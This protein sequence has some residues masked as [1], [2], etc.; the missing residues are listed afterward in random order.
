NNREKASKVT[1][2]EAAFRAV[3]LPAAPPAKARKGA[4]PPRPT[5]AAILFAD[6]Q[7]T[8]GSGKMKS[9][10]DF[11]INDSGRVDWI[12]RTG[13]LH[14]RAVSTVEEARKAHDMRADL[15]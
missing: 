13:P 2:F 3:E 12:V 6:A 10:I 14:N 8:V 11:Y 5:D 9:S 4:V 7:L 15:M 1:P